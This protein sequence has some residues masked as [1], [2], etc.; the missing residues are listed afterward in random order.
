MAH[1]LY[2][3]SSGITPQPDIPKQAWWPKF[4]STHHPRLT[5]HLVHPIL[6]CASTGDPSPVSSCFELQKVGEELL[7][8]GGEDRFGMELDPPERKGAVT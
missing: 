5:S 6:L 1:R 7:A 2:E 3:V 4:R 8:V